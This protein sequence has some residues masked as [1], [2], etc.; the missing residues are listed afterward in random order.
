MRLE[1]SLNHLISELTS[2]PIR[3]S[4]APQLDGHENQKNKLNQ[5]INSK[6]ILHTEI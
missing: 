2:K 3:Q 6:Y 1:E 5:D 4:S